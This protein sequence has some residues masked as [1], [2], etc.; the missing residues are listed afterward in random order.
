MRKYHAYTVEYTID[1]I[2]HGNEWIYSY[3]RQEALA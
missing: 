2:P 1:G 3:N